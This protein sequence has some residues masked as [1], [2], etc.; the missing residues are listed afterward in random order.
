MPARDDYDDEDDFD[1]YG[2]PDEPRPDTCP[3]CGCRRSKKVSFNWWGGAVG[4]AIFSLVK[5]SACGRQYNRKTGKPIGALHITIYTL[6]VG[7][8]FG[9]V[10]Y[11]LLW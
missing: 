9:V 11:Y 10:F 3:G 7:A 4:P 2:K 6:V 8:A 5:C 1:G